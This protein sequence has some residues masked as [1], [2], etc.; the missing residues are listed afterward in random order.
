MNE[1]S[2]DE[3]NERQLIPPTEAEARSRHRDYGGFSMGRVFV[4][5]ILILIGLA[6]LLDS[7]GIWDV[8]IALK[9]DYL[10]PVLIILLG[11]SMLSGRGLFSMVTGL[12]F[13][14]LAAVAIVY[15]FI[16]TGTVNQ[17]SIETKTI[18]VNKLAA[19]KSGV[20]AIKLGAGTINI[21]GGTVKLVAGTHK[22]NFAKLQ[23]ESELDDATQRVMM[24]AENKGL[25]I[26]KNFNNLDL[27]LNSKIPIEIKV[28]SGAS[29]LDFDL[30]KLRPES[31][32]IDSGASSIDL[33]LSPLVDDCEYQIDAGASSIDVTIPEELGVKLRLK[34]GLTSKSLPR[35]EKQGDQLYVS[36]NYNDSVKQAEIDL[37][38]GASSL[39]VDWE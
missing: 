12:L 37:D 21:A 1:R 25:I 22:S 26:G 24:Q 13:T 11:L 35:F 23:I 15:L 17:G 4:G 5:T 9:W 7:L 8:N 3:T 32:E 36:K 30:R 2:G 33:S 16:N 31:V 39:S 19:A 10:W 38:V 14:I 18:S 29:K 27:R 6:Y 20:V 34:S 28:D